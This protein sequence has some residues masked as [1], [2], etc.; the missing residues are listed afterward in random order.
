MTK[1]SSLV[2]KIALGTVQFGLDYGINNKS[3]KVDKQEVN[4]IL[5]YCK[6]VGIETLDTASAYGDSE[7]VLGSLGVN[8][9]KLISKAS[10]DQ[11]NSI[12][13]LFRES[14][15][16]LSTQ[17]LYAYLIHNFNMYD[18]DKSIWEEMEELKAHGRVQKIGISLYYPEELEELWRDGISPDIIQVP[19]NIFDRRFEDYFEKLVDLKTEIHTRSTFLQGLFFKSENLPA[20]FDE[21]RDQLNHLQVIAQ[22]NQVDI[23]TLCLSYVIN[24]EKIHKV[25]IGV[26]SL[27]Q[28]KQNILGVNNC[29]IKDLIDGSFRINNLEILIP[30][31][32][33]S[34]GI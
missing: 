32:W 5:D 24:N 16:N 4:A 7:S 17:K 19:Y 13:S 12:S 33:P 34:V 3:G 31:N 1:T 20:H 28:L 23:S 15:V 14:L 18:Q 30:S 29:V 21:I 11:T 8:D 9:F 22:Q 26:D 6:K 27:E 2:S 10:H 25:V